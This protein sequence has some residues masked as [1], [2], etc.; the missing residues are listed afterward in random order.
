M[1]WSARFL[2]WPLATVSTEGLDP[3][4]ILPDDAHRDGPV[5]PVPGAGDD[6]AEP[7]RGQPNMNPM[8]LILSKPSLPLLTEGSTGSRLTLRVMILKQESSS[9][10]CGRAQAGSRREFQ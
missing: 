3:V 6:P 2:Q 10:C 4:A 5:A 8:H 7:V 9:C 1:L